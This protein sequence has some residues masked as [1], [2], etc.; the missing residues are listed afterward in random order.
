MPRNEDYLDSLLDS[1]TEITDFNKDSARDSGKKVRSEAQFLDEFEREIARDLE[2]KSSRELVDEFERSLGLLPQEDILEGISTKTEPDGYQSA[3]KFLDSDTDNEDLLSDL[4][5]ILGGGTDS[6]IEIPIDV[7]APANVK[8][9]IENDGII[10]DVDDGVISDI[11][12]D[13]EAIPDEEQDLTA[14]ISNVIK[15]SDESYQEEA[16]SEAVNETEDFSESVT[17][18]FKSSEELS[19]ESEGEIPDIGSLL[20]SFGEDIEGNSETVTGEDL[21]GNTSVEN[22]ETDKAKKSSVFGKILEKIKEI[23]NRESQ[24]EETHE[25]EALDLQ[26]AEEIEGE[27]PEDSKAAKKKAKAEEKARKKAEK[28]EAKKKAAEEKAL[29]KANKQ[30][31]KV[32]DNSPKVPITVLIAFVILSA[33]II[34]FIYILQDSVGHR[35]AI[36]SAKGYFDSDN[37]VLAYE[38]LSGLEIKEE[39]EEETTLY[40]RSLYLATLEY[41]LDSYSMYTGMDEIKA[42]DALVRGTYYYTENMDKAEELGIQTQYETLGRQ[43]STSLSDVYGVGE[44]EVAELMKINDRKDYTKALYS[45]LERQGLW[46]LE[47]D[48]NN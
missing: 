13:T 41:R 46:S 39:N 6:D 11:E 17:E 4:A 47:D 48:S 18:D 25:E 20:D 28:E 29:K 31:N 33:S 45:I 27:T 2:T 44:T 30:K 1:V 40:K 32:P 42:I 12:D 19:Q 23:F 35:S 16:E 24:E 7:P 21:K 34:V 22:D 9:D 38:K 10:S 15:E 37:Y 5:G 8:D 3:A 43:I 36:K 26:P 14:N